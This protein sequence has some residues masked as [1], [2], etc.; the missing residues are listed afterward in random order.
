[1]TDTKALVQRLRAMSH[2]DAAR[3]AEVIEALEARVIELEDEARE[4]VYQVQLS[5]SA[6]MDAMGENG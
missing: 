5:E 3:A 6:A 4:L 1:M 2:T